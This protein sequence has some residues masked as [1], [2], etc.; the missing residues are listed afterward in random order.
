[1]SYSVAV[2]LGVGVTLRLAVVTNVTRLVPG[3][4]RFLFKLLYVYLGGFLSLELEVF[5][6]V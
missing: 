2:G 4:K 1:M 3:I 6:V 5:C